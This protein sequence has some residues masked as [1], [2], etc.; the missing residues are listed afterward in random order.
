MRH[1]V[2]K[3]KVVFS[4]PIRA[5]EKFVRLNSS[6]YTE[7]LGSIQ[8]LTVMSTWG[9]RRSVL[10]VDN[11]A[12]FMCQ[13]FENLGASN[14]WNPDGLSTALYIYSFTFVLSYTKKDDHK[15]EYTKTDLK[16]LLLF[17]N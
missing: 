10:K 6:T 2:T 14:T 11:L 17:T 4:T 12:N 13:F 3:Q 7:V 9:L 5:I 15:K 16:I 1:C 8:S